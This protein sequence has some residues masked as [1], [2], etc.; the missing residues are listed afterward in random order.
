MAKVNS[1]EMPVI[2]YEGDEQVLKAIKDWQLY[3][4]GQRNLSV[5]TFVS[6]GYDME[7]FLRFVKSLKGEVTLPVLFDFSLRDFRA[8]LAN[9]AAD[10]IISSSLARNMSALR[11]F[12]KWC[13][14]TGLGK[15]K[16]VKAVRSPRLPKIMPRPIPKDEAIIAVNQADGWYDEKQY[17]SKDDFWLGKRD[18]ALFALLYGSGLRISEALNLRIKDLPSGDVMRITGKGNKQREVP[19]LPFVVQLL[20]EYMEVRPYRAD[21]DDFLF[22][23]KGGKQLNPRVV[24]R[25]V[26]RLR[27]FL[28]LPETATPHA[29]RHSFATHLLTAGGDLRTI[30]ELLG[31]DSLAATQRYTQLDE[32][33]ISEVY[34]SAHPR[35]K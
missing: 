10:G 26:E 5:N 30:Q 22:L 33:H 9:R 24:Q 1:S 34:K 3:L 18:K 2:N 8:F 23:G 20:R 6:Y 16:S 13:D 25:Q 35:S 31:H 29:F 4:R 12:F 27:G 14:K 11:N 7:A 19:V 28:G 32:K 15:N 21:K 17:H